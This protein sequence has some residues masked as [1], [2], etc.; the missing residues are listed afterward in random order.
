[1]SDREPTQDIV[2]RGGATTTDRR[3]DRIPQW[4]QNNNKYPVRPLLTLQ[5]VRQ[6]RSYTWRA[7]IVLDQGSEGACVG[8]SWAHELAARPRVVADVN[9]DLARNIYFEA[10]MVDP[11]PG[12]SYPGADPVY[13]GSSVLA[14]AKVLQ[15]RGHF[16][17]YRWATTLTELIGA[18]GYE[19][20]VVLGINWWTGMFTPDATGFLHPTG[21][22]E[23]G[24]AILAN[25]V[26][27]KG[28]Y[29]RLHNSW[30]AGWG[31]NGEA[32]VSFD[33][34]EKL[35][36]ENGEACVPVRRLKV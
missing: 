28:K 30:G 21:M 5:Q 1:V 9:A 35:L 27:V 29:V 12:G 34:M 25:G 19:G 18:L 17:E 26:S 36:A 31:D 15:G 6:P 14:G 8:F 7:G 16:L 33:D 32:K 10:Q 20:P 13:E 3:L 2:L 24:H 23:G 4:D 22:I 11:W